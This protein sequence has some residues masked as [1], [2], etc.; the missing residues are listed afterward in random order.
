MGRLLPLNI[1]MKIRLEESNDD[2]LRQ[3]LLVGSGEE[4]SNYLNFSC[5]LLKNLD[6]AYAQANL[7][8]K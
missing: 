5:S 4:D 6:N 3:K 2:M 7:E 8:I 1:D